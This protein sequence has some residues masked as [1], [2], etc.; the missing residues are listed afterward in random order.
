[1][2][3]YT[4]I[5]NIADEGFSWDDA[6]VVMA[7]ASLT[8]DAVGN[9]GTSHAGETAYGGADGVNIAGSGSSWFYYMT[10]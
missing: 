6:F 5:I 10:S 1:M 4:V 3:S 9:A 8:V 2:D 7:H